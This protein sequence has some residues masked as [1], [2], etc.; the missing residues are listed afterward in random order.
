MVAVVP[1]PIRVANANPR[2]PVL[3]R[4]RARHLAVKR[5]VELRLDVHLGQADAGGLDAVGP[6]DD[7]GI[8]EI[9]VR[10]D[11]GRSRDFLDDLA[12]LLGQRAEGGEVGAEDLDLDGALDARQIIDLVLDQR[13]EFGLQ[14]RDLG[15][16][17]LAERVEQ[18]AHR[19]T[20]PRGLEADQ[21]VAGV[22]LGGEEAELGARPAD[23]AGDVGRAAGARPRPGACT[24]SV[25]ASEVPTGML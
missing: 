1:D 15:L 8:A 22:R 9:D 12:D 16:E 20:L 11:V 4:D 6:D 3:L 14:F 7:V 24:L 10:I 2:H 18:L 19:A 5:R 25:W 13:H 23:V 21:D 17:L